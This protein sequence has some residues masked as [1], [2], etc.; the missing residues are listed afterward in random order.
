MVVNTKVSFYNLNSNKKVSNIHFDLNENLQ[1]S[2][3]ENKRNICLHPSGILCTCITVE[4][5]M[6]FW[7]QLVDLHVFRE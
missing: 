3:E 5:P 6:P 2:L 4:T 1:L 7:G